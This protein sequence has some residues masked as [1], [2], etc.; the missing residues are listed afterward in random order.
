MSSLVASI[1]A[2]MISMT[3]RYGRLKI[4]LLAL[5]EKGKQMPALACPLLLLTLSFPFTHRFTCQDSV[6]EARLV[7]FLE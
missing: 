1:D 6:V 4:R 3:V 7:S 2:M 5:R